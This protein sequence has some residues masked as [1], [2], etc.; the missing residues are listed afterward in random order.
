MDLYLPAKWWRHYALVLTEHYQENQKTSSNTISTP[1]PARLA[2]QTVAENMMMILY[3][4][5]NPYIVLLVWI[6]NIITIFE[7]SGVG[8]EIV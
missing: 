7:N 3:L 6:F 2:L 8:K 5:Y 1:Y 4:G